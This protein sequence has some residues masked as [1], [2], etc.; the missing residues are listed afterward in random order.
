MAGFEASGEVFRSFFGAQVV[1]FAARE[2]FLMN[3]DD[4]E[5]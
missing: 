5:G 1:I 4:A 2:R 3:K